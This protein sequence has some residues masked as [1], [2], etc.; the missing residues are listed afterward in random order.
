MSH[1]STIGISSDPL[2]Q[3][4]IVVSALIHD[5]DHSGVTVTNAR[6]MAHKYHNHSAT[7]QTSVN[8]AWGILMNDRYHD[9]RQCLFEYDTERRQSDKWWS[10]PSWSQTLSI[11]NG[12]NECGLS[13]LH[14]HSYS[15]GMDCYFVKCTRPI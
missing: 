10:I 9:L 15:N 11:R 12:S 4:A 5:V 8:V 14:W 7:E 3:L 6:L 1:F 13:T 2:C